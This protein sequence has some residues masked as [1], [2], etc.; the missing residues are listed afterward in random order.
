MSTLKTESIRV[1]LTAAEKK[2]LDQFCAINSIPVGQYVRALI[3][4]SLMAG[5]P[6][7][8]PRNSGA[9]ARDYG[10]EPS[11]YKG[12]GA[13][14]VSPMPSEKKSYEPDPRP[15]KEAKKRR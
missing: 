3:R 7:L 9:W 6:A 11:G 13:P 14:D 2:V 1:R 8:P 15:V 10:N 4:D 5:Q 12:K